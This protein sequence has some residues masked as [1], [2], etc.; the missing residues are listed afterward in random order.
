MT[1]FKDPSYQLEALRKNS[2]VEITHLT[3]GETKPTDIPSRALPGSPEPEPMIIAPKP[4]AN[5][6]VSSVLDQQASEKLSNYSLESGKDEEDSTVS[7]LEAA[8]NKEKII[9][10]GDADPITVAPTGEYAVDE[11]GLAPSER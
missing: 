4:S 3:K 5:Y 10:S 9:K 7:R 11:E 2:L 6:K 1:S 8:A